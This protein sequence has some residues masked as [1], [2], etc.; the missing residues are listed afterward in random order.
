MFDVLNEQ[1]RS[2]SKNSSSHGQQV[3][4][5]SN[6]KETRKTKNWRYVLR[7]GECERT[8]KKGF[9]YKYR[10]G[11]NHV[12]LCIRGLGVSDCLERNDGVKQQI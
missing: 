10:D 8:K 5:V 2:I 9:E 6:T 7:L 1:W 11:C 3:K 12:I 4:G